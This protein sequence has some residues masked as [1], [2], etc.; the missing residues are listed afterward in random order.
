MTRTRLFLRGMAACIAASAL[1]PA[2]LAQALMVD[3]EA[4]HQAYVAGDFHRAGLILRDLLKETPDDPD[5]LRRLAAV[6]AASNDLGA[7]QV[8]IDRAISL[9]PGDPDIQ[10]ARANILFWRGRVSEAQ[11]QADQISSR[12]PG[13][14]GLD[15]LAASLQ[16]A[17][18]DRQLRLQSIGVGAS[19][20][21]AS[22][23]SGTGQTW[24]VQRGTVAARWGTG[25]I[26]AFEIEREERLTTDTRLSGRIDLP[27]GKNRYFLTGG[28]TPNADFRENWNMGGGAELAVG[29]SSTL[30][31]DGRFAEYRSDDVVALGAGLR[32]QLSPTLDLTARSIHLLGGG[33]DYR[34]GGSLQ[35]DYR[36]PR[37]PAMFAIVA[38]YPDAEIDGTRQLR[39]VAAGTRFALSEKLV[40][41][42]TGEFES[43]EDSYERFA[44]SLDLR[45]RFGE[46]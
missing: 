43:R 3:R 42:L 31:V 32:R 9:A 25:N 33:E 7:A 6:Q 36:H 21:N 38:S 26:A 14:P 30:L 41:G 17:K 1:A 37:L 35:A 22:F 46:P 20:S 28:I 34:L 2:A 13:Y 8:T 24:Y 29:Q 12:Y 19:V 23:A 45:W 15:R 5:L 4:A 27:N 39:A 40:L 18:S 16:Q 10:L 44:I 11:A